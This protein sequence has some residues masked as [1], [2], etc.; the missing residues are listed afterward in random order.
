MIEAF[1]QT[2]AGTAGGQPAVQAIAQAV[3]VGRGG[4]RAG[5]G[6]RQS[7]SEASGLMALA[8]KLLCVRMAPLDAPWCRT[9]R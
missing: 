3:Y 9:Y 2:Q 6:R 8:A 5:D 7:A 4:G 1:Q